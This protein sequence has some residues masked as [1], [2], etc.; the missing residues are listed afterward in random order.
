MHKPEPTLSKAPAPAMNMLRLDSILQC[1]PGIGP[2]RAALLAR[3]GLHTLEDLLR[4]FPRDY[5]DRRAVTPISQAEEGAV[6]TIEAEVVSARNVRLRGRQSLAVVK[7]RDASGEMNASFFGRGFLANR[8]FQPGARGFFNGTV[9]QYNGLCLKNPDYE[10]A[11]GEENETRIHGGRIVPKYVL[12]DGV[13]QR[14]LRQ[15]AH[16]ALEGAG[17]ALPGILPPKL[18][19]VH[20]FPPAAEAIRAIHFPETHEDAARARTR[21][22]FEELLA[23]QLS[24]LAERAARVNEAR[25]LRHK[26]DGPKL[27]AFRASLPFTLTGAQERV[28]A[29]MLGDMAAPHPMARLLQGDVGCGKT[30]V[31]L[32]LAAAAADGGYQTALMAPTEILA[33]QHYLQLRE[34]LAPHGIE[35]ALLT[36]AMRGAAAIRRAIAAGDTDVVVGTH[37]LVQESTAFHR[38]GL[39]IIDEQHRFGV[40]QRSCLA[41]K[42]ADADV[43]HMTATPIPRT[44]A[45]TLYGSMDLSVIDAM[46]PGRKPVKTRRI[47]P[48]K[49]PELYAYLHEEAEKGYQ[50]YIV[51]KL[52]E[53]SENWDV[54]PV[55]RHFEE[56]SAGALAGLRCEL[57]H[58]RLDSAEKDAIMRRFKDGDIDVL[59]STTVI[60]VGLDVPNATTMIIE[61]AAHFGLTQLHQLRGRV[62]RGSRQSYC[63]LLGT[64]T[65]IEG[66]KRLD[67]LCAYASGFDIAEAD[68]ELRGP[69]EFHGVRQAGLSDLRAADL[70]RDAR[71]L[72]LARR[73]AGTILEEDPELVRPE[74]RILAL[75]A[76]KRGAPGL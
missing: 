16:M 39:A 28:I 6:I 3:L 48:S 70:L 71:L 74:H 34:L 12:T 29:V 36:G 15:W 56:L 10:L 45:L 40:G 1:L 41:G 52:I 61:D 60:E 58:G 51:C 21:F 11:A 13:T 69:G 8:A 50:A 75:A 63:F 37:A 59:F 19:K 66:R 49:V 35:T 46:P 42:G 47:A 55:V 62:G 5:E 2:K 31:A 25:G 24:L 18:E 73:E 65:A 9:G 72:D 4:H 32:H 30:V 67:T 76:R 57:M 27:A 22:A 17:D 20:D 43:L 14:M 53:E 7:L 64:P 68:L 26:I 38:L 54:T 33:E 44:L 23:L